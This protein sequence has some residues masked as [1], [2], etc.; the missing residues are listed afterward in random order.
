[1]ANPSFEPLCSI[2]LSSVHLPRVIFIVCP[3]RSG[4][5]KEANAVQGFTPFVFEDP[6]RSQIIVRS[7]RQQSAIFKAR[8]RLLGEMRRC[9][10]GCTCRGPQG[11][12]RHPL[13]PAEPAQIQ[14]R[15]STSPR[16]SRAG[17]GLVARK[18]LISS[19]SNRG[20][21]DC[22]DLGSP[23]AQLE[24]TRALRSQTHFMLRQTNVRKTDWQE[25]V[26]S[27][28]RW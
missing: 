8:T 18:F 24:A 27:Y 5:G 17:S 1:M 4:H 26:T 19:T 2:T 21:T 10:S 7:T 9:V 12:Q 22:A 11:H 14:A 15:F 20:Q 25:V 3:I 6:R 28:E 13:E 16:A 23:T